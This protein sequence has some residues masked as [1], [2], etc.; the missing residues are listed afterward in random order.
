MGK[1]GI[2]VTLLPF[3]V[4]SLLITIGSTEDIHIL[5]EYLEGLREQNLKEKA[6]RYMA[7]KIGTAV[8]LTAVTTFLA[9]LS[10]SINEIT[11]LRQFGITAAF[12]LLVNPFITA[13]LAPVYLRYLGPRKKENLPKTMA[14]FNQLQQ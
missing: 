9:F 3:I 13:L 6:V 8:M 11:I 10:I 14:D 12:G 4:P 7:S 1:T 5:S 2:P